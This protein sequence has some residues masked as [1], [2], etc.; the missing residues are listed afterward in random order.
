[1]EYYKK[2]LKYK[3]K[4]INLKQNMVGGSLPVSIELK[5]LKE[6]INQIYNNLKKVDNDGV[7]FY[8]NLN[9]FNFENAVV[10]LEQFGKIPTNEEFKKCVDRED[11][12]KDYIFN[13]SGDIT[14]LIF[15]DQ[16]CR[17]GRDLK[18]CDGHI[19]C[20]KNGSCHY[21]EPLDKP[22][23]CS[24]CSMIQYHDNL[25]CLPMQK[26]KILHILETGKYDDVTNPGIIVVPN[27][28]PYFEKHFLITTY[29]H[30]T[31]ELLV[32]NKKYYETIVKIANVLLDNESGTM[33]FSAMCGYSQI[34][35]HNQYTSQHNFPIFSYINSDANDNN[36][37]LHKIQD[38]IYIIYPSPKN[39]FF[40]GLLF[41][42]ADL[43]KFSET[44][45][46]IILKT[47]ELDFLYNYVISK[48]KGLFQFILFIRSN[49]NKE[50]KFDTYEP[51][52]TKHIGANECAGLFPLSSPRFSVP[53]KSDE[54]KYV[55]YMRATNSVSNIVRVCNESNI[56]AKISETDLKRL[57]STAMIGTL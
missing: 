33:F 10:S 39:P 9:R 24:L 37:L 5:D 45:Y 32:K 1:M 34:H 25:A 57:D 17:L 35:I 15:F 43:K 2:Y 27:T 36:K 53:E 18:I 50:F 49:C 16:T 8:S 48:N 52:I 12:K 22:I 41:E 11:G 20:S 42:N 56:L 13:L 46:K 26:Y 54:N 38:G 44:I 19:Q 23:N 28:F 21:D 14:H 55:L 29:L 4:Y 3:N 7:S 40:T 47:T 6:G 30:N 51:Q 31:Q